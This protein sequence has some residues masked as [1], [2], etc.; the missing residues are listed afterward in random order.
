MK[1]R[2]VQIRKNLWERAKSRNQ[3]AKNKLYNMEDKLKKF[4]QNAKEKD[5]YENNE[6]MTYR[7]DGGRAKIRVNDIPEEN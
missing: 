2:M 7:D 4:F 6:T 1:G 5:K 3:T